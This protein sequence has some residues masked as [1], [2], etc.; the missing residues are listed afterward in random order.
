MNLKK[1]Q[2]KFNDNKIKFFKLRLYFK[3]FQKMNLY[4]FWILKFSKKSALIKIMKMTPNL[5]NF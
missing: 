4:Y 2:F 3:N 1:K 5:S